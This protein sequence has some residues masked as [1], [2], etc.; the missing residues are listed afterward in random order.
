[1]NSIKP[2]K[3]IVVL[4]FLF[5]F[6]AVAAQ[7]K[8]DVVSQLSNITG[9]KYLKYGDTLKSQIVLK[10][11]GIDTLMLTSLRFRGKTIIN[12]QT[13]QNFSTS[14]RT[15]SSNIVNKGRLDGGDTSRFEIMVI[16][17][18][19]NGYPCTKDI[20]VVIWPDVLS[21][22][23][24]INGAN[25]TTTFSPITVSKHYT[26]LR[27][28]SLSNFPSTIF[29]NQ[30]LNF[31]TTYKN[32]GIDSILWTSIAMKY[33]VSNAT[34]SN[35][36]TINFPLYNPSLPSYFSVNKS[37]DLSLQI[38]LN[39]A[40]GYIENVSYTLTVYP[41]ITNL[42]YVDSIHTNDT[43]K[44]TFQISKKLSL[45]NASNA[46]N[47]ILYPNPTS[48]FLILEKSNTVDEFE[49]ELYNIM[50]QKLPIAIQKMDLR[51]SIVDL[52]ILTKGVYLL[53]N[54]SGEDCFKVEKK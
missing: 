15:L 48:D 54:A 46:A 9:Q 13:Y 22:D 36:N 2:T 18:S 24:I 43:L 4:S 25:D 26:D 7:K 35:S 47:I 10:N 49:F 21:P 40:S 51:R 8:Y 23:S 53:R 30:N 6:G 29:L 28:E 12:K 33:T 16:A 5:L 17:D 27:Y 37:Q 19:T 52:R 32:W 1:M 31:N 41:E 39:G 50:G 20:I 34:F 45:T 3:F 42:E 38:P 11:I 44:T 14:F